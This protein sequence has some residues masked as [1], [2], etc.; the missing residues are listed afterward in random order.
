[1]SPI[2]RAHTRFPHS[3]RWP[4][5]GRRSRSAARNTTSSSRQGMTR[6]MLSRSMTSSSFRLE[7]R[8]V[9]GRLG[10]QVDDV[11]IEQERLV[12]DARGRDERQSVAA[13]GQR[14]QHILANLCSDREHEEAVAG[15]RIVLSTGTCARGNDVRRPGSE[16]CGGYRDKAR[17]LLRAKPQPAHRFTPLDEVGTQHAIEVL[18]GPSRRPRGPAV[19]PARTCGS[20][21]MPSSVRLSRVTMSFGVP[22]GAASRATCGRRRRVA[23]LRQGSGLPGAPASPDGQHRSARPFPASTC[24]SADVTAP[25]ITCTSSAS[26]A[27]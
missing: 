3:R 13:S 6:S 12:G 2:T 25:N 1:M 21:R 17:I 4:R 7:R 23:R 16:G 24:N 22:A 26:S 9:G 11:V 20:R 15:H 5:S 8:R 10:H 18:G 14:P 27:R 19:H